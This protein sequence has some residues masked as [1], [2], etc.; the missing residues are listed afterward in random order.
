MRLMTETDKTKQQ[1]QK[2]KY[3]QMLK[4]SRTGSHKKQAYNLLPQEKGAGK[5]I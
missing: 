4:G 1:N 3:L 2:K 5:P